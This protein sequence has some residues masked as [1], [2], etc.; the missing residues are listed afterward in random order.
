MTLCNILD[1]N[2]GKTVK[3]IVHNV[4]PAIQMFISSLFNSLHSNQNFIIIINHRSAIVRKVCCCTQLGSSWQHPGM[5]ALL[6]SFCLREIF[7]CPQ[8]PSSA[9]HFRNL[10]VYIIYH[11]LHL[12]GMERWMSTCPPDVLKILCHASP[13]CSPSPFFIYVLVLF[14]LSLCSLNHICNTVHLAIR[15]SLFPALLSNFQIIYKKSA[16][17]AVFPGNKK[18]PGCVFLERPSK[19][20]I[21]EWK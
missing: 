20:N 4:Q 3:E 16:S 11:S 1:E 13:A 17:E 18:S 21:I 7:K 14:S 5:S 15:C 9:L 8:V 10:S 19:I 2:T 12:L 6:S